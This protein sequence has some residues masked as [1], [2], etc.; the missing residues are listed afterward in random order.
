MFYIHPLL[1]AI[2]LSTIPVLLLATR[3]FQKNI[4]KTFNDV[5]IQV[6]KLNEF[7][8]EHLVA[9]RIVQLFNREEEELNKFHDINAKH[10]DANIRS[11]W[12]YSLFFPVVEILSAVSIGLIVWYGG[13]NVLQSSISLGLLV[14][15]IQYI[16]QLFRPIREL[17]DKFNTLQM[18]MVSSERV[19]KLLDEPFTEVNSGQ[20][21]AD[22]IIG[23]I[24]FR[25]VWFAYKNEE[26]ILRGLSFT[27]PAGQSVAIVGA[28]GAGK[29]TI[30]SLINRL[31]EIQ[32]GRILIDD[33]DIREYDLYSLRNAI[34]VVLQDVF[35]FS[36]SIKNNI[37][38]YK[39]QDD[40]VIEALLKQTGAWHFVE[41]LPGQLHY[42]P[43]ERGG[44]I[45][46]GQRQLLSF[47]RVLAHH[48]KLIILDEATSSVDSKLEQLLVNATEVLTKNRTSIIIAHRLSTIEKADRII[49]LQKGSIVEDGNHQI[50]LQKK[51]VYAHLHEVQFMQP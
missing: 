4:R 13:L 11:I 32:K 23:K 18:G 21:S 8:Q 44:L 45:S 12:Y 37:T 3:V 30:I 28:T 40:I 42:N 31:Y 41:K 25:D 39:E 46:T 43:G 33:I 29:T 15:F 49:V 48:P 22:K 17:A 5:R 2:S 19:F 7:V 51:G 6:A 34:G 24:E 26:W 10:R 27:I 47:A 9:M 50:L 16:N 38:L 1:A 36:D 35:L 14:A 20:K